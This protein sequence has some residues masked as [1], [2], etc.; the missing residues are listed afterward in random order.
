MKAVIKRQPLHFSGGTRFGEEKGTD[1][2][3]KTYTNNV[4]WRDSTTFSPTLP[5][6]DKDSDSSTTYATISEGNISI[7]GKDTTV[8]NLGIHSDINTANQ[9]VDAL[10]DLRPS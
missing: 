7:G 4:N 10:P 3:G 8:E 2:T 9:K 5:Q 1:S 6:Q